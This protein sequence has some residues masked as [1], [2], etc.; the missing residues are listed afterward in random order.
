MT[1]ACR[2][3]PAPVGVGGHSEDGF[4]LVEL[5]IAASLSLVIV[6]TAIAIAADVQRAHGHALEDASAQQEARY[7][8]DWIARAIATAGNNAYGINPAAAPTCGGVPLAALYPDPNG[9]GMHDDLRVLAD[10]NP[11][12]GVLVGDGSTCDESGEDVTIAI[13]RTDRVITRRDR[14][15]DTGALPATDTVFADLRFT[16]FTADRTETTAAGEIAIVRVAVTAQSRARH[17]IT[18]AFTRFT[19]QRAI[20]LRSR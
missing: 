16:Y 2:S 10:I 9:D 13:D 3:V 4:T 7:A 5:L 14:A 8:L 12:N 15:A 17:P 19:Y 6:G 1:G 18:G 11:P 20:R